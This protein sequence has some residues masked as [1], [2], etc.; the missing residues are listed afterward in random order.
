MNSYE[1]VWKIEAHE[2]DEMRAQSLKELDTEKKF[3]K[4]NGIENNGWPPRTKELGDYL[5]DMYICIVSSFFSG[6]LA[7]T[8]GKALPKWSFLIVAS[9]EAP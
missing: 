8:I 6:A 1:C 3:A 2:S 7:G 4:L 9:F 5:E